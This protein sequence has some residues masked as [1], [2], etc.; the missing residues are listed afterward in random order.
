[1]MKPSPQIGLIIHYEYLWKSE[2]LEGENKGEKHR[3]C[4]QKCLT[5]G[6]PIGLLTADG[7]LYMLMEEEHDP[8]RDGLGTFRA[9]AADH[10]AHVME[11]TGTAWSHNGYHALYVTGFLKK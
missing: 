11:V 10:I 9:A 3:P 8:R 7:T 5:A 1:M 4:G 6:A 2:Q